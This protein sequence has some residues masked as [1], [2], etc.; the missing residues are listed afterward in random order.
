MPKFVEFDL[1]IPDLVE[2]PEGWHEITCSF[3]SHKWGVELEEG[4]YRVV[5]LD[6]CDMEKF[7]P[8]GSGIPACHW[9]IYPEDFHTPAPI[10]VK[11][12][13]VDDSTPSTPMGP[14]EYGFYVEVYPEGWPE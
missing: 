9:E 7:N 5:C 14:A 4:N 12:N 2:P 10:P 8:A 11:L 1:D 13:Y 6:P 3:D